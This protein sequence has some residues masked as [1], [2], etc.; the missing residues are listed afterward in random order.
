MRFASDN[1]DVNRGWFPLPRLANGE[2]TVYSCEAGAQRGLGRGCVFGRKGSTAQKT[3]FH[4]WSAVGTCVICDECD[5]GNSV[6]FDFP[7]R[8]SLPPI[9]A[10]PPFKVVVWCRFGELT[11]KSR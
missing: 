5:M 1:A 6:L 7:H 11:L 8:L 3:L 4:C 2:A 9:F 10:L